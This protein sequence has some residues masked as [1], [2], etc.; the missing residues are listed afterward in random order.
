[1]PD[2]SQ[3]ELVTITLPLTPT[4]AHYIRLLDAKLDELTSGMDPSTAGTVRKKAAPRYAS[5]M[6]SGFVTDFMEHFSLA[7]TEF[8]VKVNAAGAEWDE[9][10]EWGKEW[11]E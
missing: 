9:Q 7:S 11:S 5:L 10:C 3:I 8:M 6:M 2:L 1:M 4:T